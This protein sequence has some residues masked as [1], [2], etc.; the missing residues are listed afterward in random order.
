MAECE[1]LPTSIETRVGI[2]QRNHPEKRDARGWQLR[3]ELIAAPSAWVHDDVAAVLLIGNQIFCGGWRLDVLD[4][5][6]GDDERRFT[7]LA[8]R[9][10]TDLSGYR[11]PTIGAAFAGVARRYEMDLA[12]MC[13][14]ATERVP[15]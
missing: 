8:T 15:R 10:M 9:L 14:G 2:I 13:D 3:N 1:C 5:I 11:E 12:N 6:S 4:G 7:E